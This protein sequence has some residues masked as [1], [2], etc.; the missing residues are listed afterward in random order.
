MDVARNDG[1]SSEPAFYAITY[2]LWFLLLGATGSPLFIVLRALI[3][4][5]E[6]ADAIKET[7]AEIVASS[8]ITDSCGIQSLRL[9]VITYVR[10]CHLTIL[11]YKPQTGDGIKMVAFAAAFWLACF[12]GM[13]WIF[14]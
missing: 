4:A 6:A 2:T 1:T 13:D 3:R 8:P 5:N 9:F 14:N 7:S 12:T 10:S 11:G